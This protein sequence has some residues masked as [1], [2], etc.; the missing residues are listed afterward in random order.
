MT[1]AALAMQPGRSE[2][3][4]FLRVMRNEAARGTQSLPWWPFLTLV[5]GMVS[6]LSEG[7]LPE[8]SPPQECKIAAAQ[9]WCQLENGPDEPVQYGVLGV[10]A[11]HSASLLHL[12]PGC[13]GCRPAATVHEFLAALATLSS[14]PSPSFHEFSQRVISGVPRSPLACAHMYVCICVC[15]GDS[16][17][18]CTYMFL[19]GGWGGLRMVLNVFLDSFHIPR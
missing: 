14:F 1:T 4:L 7:A 6:S 2:E 3:S 8:M 13:R 19:L 17:C 12:P 15:T 11:N 16:P 5:E 10:Y 18:M 9:K